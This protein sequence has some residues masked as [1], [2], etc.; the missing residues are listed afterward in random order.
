[1]ESFNKREV[2]E[3]AK[4]KTRSKNTGNIKLRGAFR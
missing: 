2:K 4:K 3:K 1:M